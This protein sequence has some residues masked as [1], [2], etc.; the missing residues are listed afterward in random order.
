MRIS[1]AGHQLRTHTF[2]TVVVGSGAAGLN[3]ASALY[4]NGQRNV[5]VVTEGL[6]RGTSR[7][8]GS[9]KQTY[10]KLTTS[11]GQGD[12]VQDMARS[13]YDGGAMHGDIALVE[14]AMSLQGFYNL[15]RIGVPFPHN[16]YGE[17]VGYKTDHDPRQRGSS[18]GP[19]TSRCMVEKLQA[20]VEAADI[21]VL[22]GLQVIAVLTDRAKTRSTGLLALE[23]N[24]QA[25]AEERFVLISAENIVYAVGG[26]AGLY[27]RSVYP[28]SQNGA[29][30]IA[31]EAGAAGQNVTESQ[32]GLASL[33][34]RWNLSGT[35][36]QVLPRYISTDEN[37]GDARE[38]LQ[39]FFPDPASMLE[40][41]FL[42]GYQWPFDPRKTQDYGSSLIDIVVYQ[43]TILRGR[44]VFLDYLH[45]P[46][47]KGEE[48]DFD[49]LG[50]ESRSYL[51]NSRALFGRP[52]DRLLHMNEPA[53]DLYRSHGIDLTREPLELA[54]CAQHN[55]GG[56]KGNIW[57]E[58][59]LKH[60]FPVGEVN[61][62]HGVYRPG[63]SALNAG[64]VGSMRAAQFISARYDSDPMPPEQL[65]Q[66]SGEQ[67]KAKLELSERFLAS[68]QGKSVD[69]IHRH[70]AETMDRYGGC[71]RSDDGL[72]AALADLHKL[73]DTLGDQ[74]RV[75]PQE[76]GHAFR[77]YDRLAAATAYLTAVQD[78]IR[79]GGCS[80]GS[81]LIADPDGE[82]PLPELPEDFRHRLDRGR[83]RNQV[84]E[85]AFSPDGWR[86]R[87]IPVRPIPNEDHWFEEV[88]QSY[89]EDGV[90]R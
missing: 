26:P 5:A 64:Q 76:L 1:F 77:N 70:T 84:Q 15:V 14:A 44:R 17:Y 16:R 83:M 18:I 47:W 2:N 68:R 58:S 10:Y 87:W 78:Y 51:E 13:L 49:W 57:W 27:G 90:I 56:L 7:N 50:D 67:I 38:F 43:E 29:T 23:R 72:E 31:L 73:W 33:K 63:G 62:S 37:G 4:H 79:Q 30:G 20:Q 81:Y 88:W 75:E 71:I 80:R 69:E 12:S 21:P 52:I 32:F 34:F 42:K 61:G 39:E 24:H 48:L 65:L 36:Q 55:N 19:L 85:I 45:N 74:M 41:A 59:N 9:D 8:T 6:K 25:A 89:R 54:V 46:T 11:G 28:P 3:A 35:Y 60:F 86:T 22:E 82:L 66:E 40:A 53:V